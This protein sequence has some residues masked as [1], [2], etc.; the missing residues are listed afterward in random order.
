[1][2]PQRSKKPQTRISLGRTPYLTRYLFALKFFGES[3]YQ[4]AVLNSAIDL[5]R[6]SSAF[7]HFRM[8]KY[9][10]VN[11]EKWAAKNISES[12][13]VKYSKAT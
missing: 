6:Y 1:M 4:T 3:S 2:H 13:E 7:M 8:M 11:N 12:N 9:R 5:S 10:S